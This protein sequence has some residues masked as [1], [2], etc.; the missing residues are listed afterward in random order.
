MRCGCNLCLFLRRLLELFFQETPP[1]AK[2]K[3]LIVKAKGDKPI[4]A[5]DKAAIEAAQQLYTTDTNTETVDD[6]AVAAALQPEPVGHG[7]VALLDEAVPPKFVSIFEVS[8][9]DP[10]GW[11]ER[12]IPFADTIDA[13]PPPQF[14]KK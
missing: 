4:V 13:T 7:P 1:V 8:T 12:Q 2:V 11:A 9:T 14:Q 5:S 6:S 3:D 10:A